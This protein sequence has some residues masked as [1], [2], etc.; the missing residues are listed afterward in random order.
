MKIFVDEIPETCGKCM[1]YD[2]SHHVGKDI[3]STY[4]K[5]CILTRKFIDP[6]IA[7]DMKL[8]KGCP[9]KLLENK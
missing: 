5:R 1:F 6:N 7:Y 4:T 2:Y 3:D 8:V 9:L